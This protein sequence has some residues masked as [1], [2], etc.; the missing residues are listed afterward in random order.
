MGRVWESDGEDM[1]KCGGECDGEGDG[2][3]CGG[4]GVGTY[5]C[6]AL[7]NWSRVVEGRGCPN[8]SNMST[9]RWTAPNFVSISTCCM[10]TCG[11]CVCVCVCVCVE[12]VQTC[13]QV[14]VCLAQTLLLTA[15]L[16]P[17]SSYPSHALSPPSSPLTRLK[18][19]M[20]FMKVGMSLSSPDM[21]STSGST[22]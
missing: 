14:D 15:S 12:R 21:P 18:V 17:P 2:G 4:E 20:S 13:Q 10:F 22:S 11:V 16:F 3:E 6:G 1:G 8:L 19:D 7:M 5:L 9:D